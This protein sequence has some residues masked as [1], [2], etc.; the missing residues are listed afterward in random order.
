MAET[1]QTKNSGLA[2]LL[3]FLLPGLGQIYNGE[4]LRGV[5]MMIA[6]SA[7]STLYLTHVVFGDAVFQILFGR[8]PYHLILFFDNPLFAIIGS[9]LWI[10]SMY[11]AYQI[12]ERTGRETVVVREVIKEPTT[13]AYKPEISLGKATSIMRNHLGKSYAHILS[14]GSS[15]F[16]TERG[17]W[18]FVVETDKGYYLVQV[19]NR[20]NVV[21]SEELTER[22]EFQKR[23]KPEYKTEDTS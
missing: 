10:R 6:V 13:E 20:G 4:I 16:R 19:D 7:L 2:V 8:F 5:L 22:D 14:I 11:D 3:S 12:A 15:K 21:K 23:M 17:A 1:S 9:L 18:E